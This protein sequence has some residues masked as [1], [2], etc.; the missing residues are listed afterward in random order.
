MTDRGFA[1]APIT[2]RPLE[3]MAAVGLGHA[4][5]TD[6]HGDPDGAALEAGVAAFK[7]GEHD[8]VV[9]FVGGAAL[10]LDK[11]VAFIAGQ[12]L[13]VW[14]FEDIGDSWTRADA[15]RIAPIVVAPMTAGT[16]SEVGRA[17]VLTNAEALEKKMIFHPCSLP[18]H[19]ICDPERTRGLSPPL[20]L[21]P[22]WMRSR[23]A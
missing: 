17:G 20:P 3:L 22:G 1:E 8:G 14:D 5:F 9:A 18:T 10:D 6:V 11:L 12:T 23:I 16:G 7:T 13:P 2:T 4:T 19:V 21:G 15:E